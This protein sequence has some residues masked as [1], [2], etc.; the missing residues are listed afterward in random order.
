[1]LSLLKKMMMMTRMMKRRKTESKSQYNFCG[2][3]MDKKTASE[4]FDNTGICRHIFCSDCISQHVAV[5]IKENVTKVKCPDPKCKGVIG[6]EAC[7]SIVPK[8]VLERWESILCESLIKESQKFYCP[9]K[10]CSAMLV[11][12]GGVVVTQSECPNCNRLFCAQC[13]VAWHC[14]ISC[15]EFQG[16]KKGKRNRDHDKLLIDLAK[17]KKWIKCSKCMLFVEKV[18]GC[19]YIYCRCGN[20][21]CYLCGQSCDHVATHRCEV[22]SK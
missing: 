20:G 3:C 5:K 1:M 16:S 17:K 21:F 18:G 2:I 6:P 22:V 4:L 7:R 10:D 11:D 13:K 12:D 9:F 19:D 8:E 14:G 15:V